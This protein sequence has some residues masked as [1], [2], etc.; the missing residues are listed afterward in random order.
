MSRLA[1]WTAAWS[2]LASYKNPTRGPGLSL[3]HFSLKF[4][5]YKS[6]AKPR[7]KYSNSCGNN[8][9]GTKSNFTDHLD[10]NNS[11]IV[12]YYVL[13]NDQINR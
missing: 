7:F 8:K 5:D 2:S 11:L 1:K 9:I 4:R 13:D 12:S 6:V 3:R 10:P